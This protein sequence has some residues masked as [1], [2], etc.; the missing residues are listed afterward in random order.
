MEYYKLHFDK[1][2]EIV[3][4]FE[5]NVNF[6]LMGDY[7]FSDS[8]SW[9]PDPNGICKPYNVNGTIANAFV[10][11][12]AITNLFQFNSVKNVNNR[13]LDLVLSNIDLSKVGLTHSDNVLLKEDRHHPALNITI[14][15][16]PLKFFDEKRPPKTN[17]FRANYEQIATTLSGINWSDRLNSTDLDEAVFSFYDIL[18]PIIDQIPKTRSANNRF[19]QWYSNELIDLI[20]R[21]QSAKAKHKYSEKYKLDSVKADYQIFVKLR[22]SVKDLIIQCRLAYINDIEDKIDVNPKAFFSYT[23]SLQKSNSLP[24]QMQLNDVSADVSSN[25][26]DLFASFFESVYNDDTVDG[27]YQEVNS[28]TFYE[29]DES[30][31][32]QFTI[33]REDVLIA[34]RLFDDCKVSTPD[35]VPM[36]FFKKLGDV[37]AEPLVILFNKS[38]ATGKFATY[39]KLSDFQVG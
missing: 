39:W 38:L 9:N 15:I 29:D 32:L 33:Q 34:L 35:G 1:L 17:F 5:S 12:L 13:S 3:N 6:L 10:D 4:G 22:R 23:K 8:I 14:D 27:M 2:I 18:K 24:N 25:L 20:K 26:C 36:L 31:P 7:N 28:D 21:K 30:N 37:I 16:N 11:F 19:P